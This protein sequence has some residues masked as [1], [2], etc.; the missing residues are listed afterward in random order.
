MSQKFKELIINTIT[1]SVKK[2]FVSS[3]LMENDAVNK[4]CREW[5]ICLLESIENLQEMQQTMQRTKN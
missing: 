2:C 5:S 4:A 1:D 3:L